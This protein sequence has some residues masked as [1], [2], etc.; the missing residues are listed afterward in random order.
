MNSIDNT[1][2][3]QYLLKR[4]KTI[5]INQG[6]LY[7]LLASFFFALMGG[8]AKKL[9]QELPAI[10]VTFFRNI[11]GVL[12]IGISL[13][14]KPSIKKGGKPLIL[15]FRG[16]MGFL[17]LLA[18][19]HNMKYIPLGDAIIYNKTA[20]L[21]LGFFA[22][23]FLREKLSKPAV[24]ALVLGFVGILFISKPTIN[25]L[26]KY[27]LLGIF[28]GIGAALAYT[29]IRRLKNCYDARTITISFMIAGTLFPLVFM[30]ISE[31]IPSLEAYDIIFSK[32]IFPKRISWIYISALTACA[33]FSQLLMTKAYTLSKAGLVGIISYSQIIFSILIGINMGDPLPDGQSIV[34]VLIIIGA[35]ILS[36]T[37]QREPQK[38]R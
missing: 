1:K 13:W 22:C 34:G 17:A 3:P 33:T 4:D 23:V 9:G 8:F 28:S 29:S 10:E 24:L 12:F 19:F 38:R 11:F 21:F 35:G 16:T 7:M 15:F 14:I 5:K 20:P 32:F 18:Y 2:K 27:D 6:A 36:I 25:G 37:T 31:V 26:S 30:G